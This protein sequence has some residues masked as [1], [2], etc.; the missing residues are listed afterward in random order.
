V[1][2]RTTA[3]EERRNERH[4]AKIDS[5]RRPTA[6]KRHRAKSERATASEERRQQ[7]KNSDS[8]RRI[9]GVQG[10]TT[11]RPTRRHP[12]SPRRRI[13]VNRPLVAE[14]Y[15]STATTRVVI[16]RSRRFVVKVW[17][18]GDRFLFWTIPPRKVRIF[19]GSE[20]IRTF[21]RPKTVVRIIVKSSQGP[22]T[23]RS[24]RPGSRYEIYESTHRSA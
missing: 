16:R 15:R 23:Y 22:T 19:A 14:L 11:R 5:Q 1:K 3:S 7:V 24:L 4:R 12:L 17:E 9:D 2:K 18:K 8:V 20:K 6:S 10:T 13:T 21:H